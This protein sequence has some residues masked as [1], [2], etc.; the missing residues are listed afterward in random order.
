[1]RYI[2]PQILDTRKAQVSIKGQNKMVDVADNG[3]QGTASAYEA[4]E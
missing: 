4:D 3:N 1:M 2:K